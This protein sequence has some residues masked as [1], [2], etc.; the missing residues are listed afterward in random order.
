MPVRIMHASALAL[1]N[2]ASVAVVVGV[3]AVMALTVARRR[4]HLHWPHF[5][6]EVVVLLSA[7]LLYFLVRGA[8]EGSAA[9]AAENGMRIVEWERSLGLYHEEWLQSLIVDDQRLVTLMNW[10]YIWGHWPVIAVVATWLLVEHRGAYAQ[11]R[12]AFLI[13]GGIGL[14]IF[15]TFPVAP[16]RLLD[17]GMVDTVTEQ[18]RAYRVLQPPQLTN[19]Y[20]AMPSLHFGWN[21]LVGLTLAR[22][23]THWTAKA[24]GILMPMAMLAA[25]VLTANHYIL[26]AVAGGAVAMSGLAVA[27][28]LQ[29]VRGRLELRRAD[30]ETGKA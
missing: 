29:R 21:L 9:A 8:T 13:S 19:I 28:G 12:T 27:V 10:I 17:L 2:V 15:A 26:D 14:V 1:I 6:T 23:S 4:R 25:V 16:P 20:A 3:A 30:M 18:S 24:F 22:V 5:L 11:V 7:V